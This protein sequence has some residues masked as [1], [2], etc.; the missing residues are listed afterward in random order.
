MHRLR[1]SAGSIGAGGRVVRMSQ[2]SIPDDREGGHL[3][4]KSIGIEALVYI[5]LDPPV[6]HDIVIDCGRGLPELRRHFED[7]AP[8][9][10]D[11][12]K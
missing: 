11:R 6:I 10:A 12:R 1:M 5:G 4:P 7:L 3:Y 9:D 2:D 8:I